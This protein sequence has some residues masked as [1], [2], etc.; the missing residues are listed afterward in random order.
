MGSAHDEAALGLLIDRA[1]ELLDDDRQGVLDLGMQVPQ[2]AARLVAPPSQPVLFGGQADLLRART[3]AP[4]RVMR[5]ASRLLFD[6]LA[7]VFDELGFN[8]V[9]DD[10]FRDLVIARIVEPTSLLDVD[11]VLADLGRV[12]A[13]LSTRKRTLARAHKGDYRDQIAAACFARARSA[14]DV[15]LVLYDVTTLYFE[16]EKE[17]DLRKVGYS[18]YAAFVVMPRVLVSLRVSGVSLAVSAA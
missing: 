8:A 12:S 16:A 2:R 15:S 9:G 18:N 6:V 5:T 3:V 4:A 17:D 14:G 1:R 13:S 10:C 11:R 7:D